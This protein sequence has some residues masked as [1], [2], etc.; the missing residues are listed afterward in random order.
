MKVFTSLEKIPENSLLDVKMPS[1]VCFDTIKIVSS[2]FYSVYFDG[3]LVQFGPYRRTNRRL[4]CNEVSLNGITDSLQIK[5]IYYGI[6]TFDL[7]C[8]EFLFGIEFYKDGEVVLSSSDIKL[9]FDEF[10]VSESNRFSFQRGF[11]ERY[12]FT[13]EPSSKYLNLKEASDYSLISNFKDTC[14]YKTAKPKLVS[15]GLFKGFDNDVESRFYMKAR[16]D[17]FDVASLV[18]SLKEN[19]IF[20]KFKYDR[21]VSGIFRLEFEVEEEQTAYLVFDEFLPDG[22]WIYARSTCNELIEI[23][24][25]K[26]R[27]IVYSSSP[28]SCMHAIVIAEKELKSV[29]VQTVLIQNDATKAHITGEKDI[30]EVL[31]AAKRTFEQNAFDLFT[32]CPGRERSGWLCDSYFEG[33]AEPFYTGNHQ[34]EKAYLENFVYEVSPELPPKMVPM[35]YP[36]IH[37]DHTF[38]PNWAM[39]FVIEIA[40]YYRDTGDRELVESLKPKVMDVLSYFEQFENELGLLE[41]LQSWEFVE[42][43]DATKEEYLKPISFISNMTYKGALDAAYELYGDEKV[44]EKSERLKATINKLSFNGRY[45]LDNA[46]RIN[47]E[48]VATKNLIS[49]TAQYYAYFFNI[50]RDEA[51][52]ENVVHAGGDKTLAGSAVF[53]GKFLRLLILFENRKYKEILDEFVPYFGKMAKLTGTLWEKEDPNASCNHGFA[54][55]L[56]PILLECYKNS[57]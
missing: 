8:R 5:V 12:D 57:H 26:G 34:I 3:R 25:K 7:D 37:E 23:K 16:Q 2:S 10:H 9:K 53:I 22:K 32:D 24:L 19:H 38:I 11:I 1:H 14:L 56:G 41:N 36:A 18:N 47:G 28:Y 35:S 40:R 6:P 52:F 49:E 13:K 54:S 43:S 31:T 4:N 55:V 50:R 20:Y 45:F 44:F 27:N 46:R 33:L 29:D 17:K 15:H 21:I 48:V 30:D 39:W 42:W 51:F